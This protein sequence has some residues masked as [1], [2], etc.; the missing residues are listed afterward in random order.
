MDF[1]DTHNIQSIGY[2]KNI[3]RMHDFKRPISHYTPNDLIYTQNQQLIYRKNIILR[4]L[5][6]LLRK[7]F[8]Y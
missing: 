6:F 7:S 2:K 4:I 3:I 5:C 8:S 1:I